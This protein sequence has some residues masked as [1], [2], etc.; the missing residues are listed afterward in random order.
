MP[1]SSV[2]F[3]ISDS[4]SSLS[5]LQLLQVCRYH[6]AVIFLQANAQTAAGLRLTGETKRSGH[7]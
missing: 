6:S 5:Y 1:D 7:G 3:C 4:L 2:T